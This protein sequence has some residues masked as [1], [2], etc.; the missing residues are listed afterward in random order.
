[1]RTALD[2]HRALLAADVPHEIVRLTARVA[3]ADEL[4]DALGLPTGCLA[5]RLYRACGQDGAVRWAAVL[6]PAGQLPDPAA[7]LDALEAVSVRTATPAEAN[8]LTGCPADL[9]TPVGLPAEVDVL[10]DAALG[11]TDV[12]YAPAAEG[13]VALGVRTRDLLVAVRA[14][15]ASLTPAPA[16]LPGPRYA[17]IVDLDLDRRAARVVPEPPAQRE[18]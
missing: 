11:A 18:R 13:G 5:V 17:D 8:A 9:V 15:A 14:R 10:A 3:S 7:L 4:P 1:M 6:V 12:V 2:V 16:P